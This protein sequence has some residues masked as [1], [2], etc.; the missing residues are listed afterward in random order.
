MSLTYIVNEVDG[1]KGGRH[2]RRW[3]LHRPE[4]YNHQISFDH[5]FGPEYQHY[6]NKK[7]KLSYHLRH[8]DDWNRERKIFED[9]FYRCVSEHPD[10]VS[11]HDKK[12]WLGPD[13]VDF[14]GSI[15]DFYKLIEYDYKKKKFLSK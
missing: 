4:K 3:R 13:I 9:S 11:L 5:F 10:K 12:E 1:N 2:T 8:E 7:K 14:S 6:I 15:F